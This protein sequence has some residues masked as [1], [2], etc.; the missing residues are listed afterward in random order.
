MKYRLSVLVVVLLLCLAQVAQATEKQSPSSLPEAIKMANEELGWGYF[1]QV[2]DFSKSLRFENLSNLGYVLVYGNAHGETSGTESRY[3]GYTKE[4]ED[5]TNPKFPHD[6]WAGGKLEDRTWIKEPWMNVPGTVANSFDGNQKYLPNIQA[7]LKQYYADVLKGESSPY[8]N[9]WHQH[10][11]ILQPPTY[12]TWGMGRMWHMVSGKPWYITVPL[13]PTAFLEPKKSSQSYSYAGCFW[14]EPKRE[15]GSYYTYVIRA[16]Y[17]PE[18]KSLLDIKEPVKC[19]TQVFLVGPTKNQDYLNT[20]TMPPQSITK[21]IWDEE[22][23][24]TKDNPVWVKKFT[25]PVPP[26]GSGYAIYV[27][28]QGGIY[29]GID[30]GWGVSGSVINLNGKVYPYSTYLTS[31]HSSTSWLPWDI[32]QAKYG[33]SP[34]Y[35]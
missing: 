32:I 15:G 3:L 26:S 28:D 23:T 14:D 2:N 5:Y 31:E 19:R 11:H 18:T 34:K 20:T 27:Q 21:L 13:A 30:N 16:P 33:L 6:A 1:K 7:G 12:W 10:I 29:K 22:I 25:M 9:N 8:W 4:D 35:N 17:V 24:F